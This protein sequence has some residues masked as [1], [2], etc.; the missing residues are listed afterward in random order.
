MV[1]IGSSGGSYE[2]G[3]GDGQPLIASEFA[4][5]LPGDDG[6]DHQRIIRKPS[7]VALPR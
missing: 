3:S 4:D 5:Q 1:E 7:S 2:H 6:A